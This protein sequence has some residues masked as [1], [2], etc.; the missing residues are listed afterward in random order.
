MTSEKAVTK[1]FRLSDRLSVEMTVGPAGFTCEWSPEVPH[2][3]SRRER[4]AYMRARNEMLRKLV[5]IVGG[6]V[7]VVD[8]DSDGRLLTPTLIGKT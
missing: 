8:V 1:S 6:D 3:L 2:E 5:E 4:R 7:A